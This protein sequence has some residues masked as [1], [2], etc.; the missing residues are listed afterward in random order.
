MSVNRLAAAI[1]TAVVLAA[2]IAGL[3]L[4]GSPAEQ[5]LLRM[6]ERRVRDLDRLTNVIGSYTRQREELPDS[7][8]QLLDGQLL[9]ELPVDPATGEPYE[10]LCADTSYQLCAVFAQPARDVDEFDFWNHPAGRHCFE[11]TPPEPR[12][13]GAGT[14]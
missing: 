2:V 3:Y 4:A 10:Y 13:T 5:R 11:F 12:P 8:E 1:S 14:D 6:D 9:D 7:L